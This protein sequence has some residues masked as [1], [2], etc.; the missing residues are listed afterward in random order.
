MFAALIAASMPGFWIAQ[1]MSLL[2]ALK[3]GWLPAT[4]IDSWKCYILPVVANAI[5]G[6]ASMARQTRSRLP[7]L[8]RIWMPHGST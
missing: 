5:G 7:I 1:M 3:L 8:L 4:G 6:I 2:F